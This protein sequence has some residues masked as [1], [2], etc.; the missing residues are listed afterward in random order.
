MRPKIE[1]AK[2]ENPT[3][4]LLNPRK[5]IWCKIKCA[6]VILFMNLM[7]KSQAFSQTPSFLFYIL[8]IVSLF[9]KF[10][11]ERWAAPIRMSLLFAQVDCSF[12]S[13]LA[14]KTIQTKII[15]SN[16]INSGQHFNL[17]IGPVG[18]PLSSTN[19]F[20]TKGPLFFSPQNPSVQH[21][22]PLSST[23]S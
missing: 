23:P 7:P 8:L 2:Y 14:V 4:S 13:N 22:K 3:R 1:W 20:N 16:D 21:R 18:I 11:Q 9:S 5:S 10:T 12:I 19:K 6:I 17:A 15:R